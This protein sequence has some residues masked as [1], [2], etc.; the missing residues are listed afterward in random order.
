MRVVVLTGAGR[1]FSAGG[2]VSAMT[3]EGAGG[4]GAGEPLD[5]RSIMEV[6]ELLHG[7]PAVTIAAVNGPCAGAGLSFACACDLRYAARSALFVSAFLRVGSSGDHGS[8][9][10]LTQAVGPAK[11]RELL[12]LGDRVGA[13]EALRI[14]LVSAVVDDGELLAHVARIAERVAG[15]PPTATRLMKANLDD[16]L[17]LRLGEYLDRETERFAECSGSDEAIVAAKAFLSK[18]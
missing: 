5:L 9:W 13:D 15:M 7:M 17:T 18:S 14:G 4:G 8:A 6:S 2:D 10:V 1:G 11:A 12:F 16:A 3:G